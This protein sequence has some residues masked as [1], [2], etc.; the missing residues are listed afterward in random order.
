MGNAEL[1]KNHE[2]VDLSPPIE[3]KSKTLQEK[4]GG[5]TNFSIKQKSVIAIT[6]TTDNK[7]TGAWSSQGGYD[8]Y[9]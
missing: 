5:K 1:D 9:Y 2:K 4:L 3:N 7:S 6:I 8:E